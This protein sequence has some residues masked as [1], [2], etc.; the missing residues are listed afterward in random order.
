[1]HP[2]ADGFEMEWTEDESRTTTWT[3]ERSRPAIQY[4]TS[5]IGAAP[6]LRGGASI[7]RPPPPPGTR[8]VSTYRIV[9]EYPPPPPPVVSEY[10]APP[11]DVHVYAPAPAYH[12]TAPLSQ[13]QTEQA[14]RYELPPPALTASSYT[15]DEIAPAREWNRGLW[16]AV[17]A[18]GLFGAVLFMQLIVSDGAG[19]A[20]KSVEP[21][22]AP[23][24][25]VIAAAPGAA[26]PHAREIAAPEHAAI[27]I[28]QPML[29]EPK[30]AEPE[31]AAPKI[32]A[33]VKPSAA[34]LDSTKHAPKL[35]AAAPVPP[36]RVAQPEPKPERALVRVVTQPVAPTQ[37]APVANPAMATLRVNSLPW[38]EIFVDG[39]FAGNTPQP[40]LALPAGRHTIKLVNAQ[41]EMSKTFSVELKPG[42]VV[43]KT[44]NLSQ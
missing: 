25:A 33:N 10:P 2:V 24:A 19:A 37:G 30:P 11:P 6:A 28:A 23:S 38:A 21:V 26:E 43:T 15:T 12:G 36:K 34:K 22:R 42:Q 35:A 3:H 1:M 40:S 27:A 39:T 4:A 31:P 44:I 20:R 18:A 5:L 9:P 16:T 14:V 17:G 29:V 8:S 32:A 41:L 13:L 7:M